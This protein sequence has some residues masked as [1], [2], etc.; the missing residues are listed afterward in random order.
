MDMMWVVQRVVSAWSLVVWCWSVLTSVLS[1][2]GRASVVRGGCGSLQGCVCVVGGWGVVVALVRCWGLPWK[3]GFTG[4]YFCLVLVVYEFVVCILRLI[5][6]WRIDMVVSAMLCRVS[7]VDFR[8]WSMC[9][10]V[11][12]VIIW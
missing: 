11:F 5:L 4:T 9:A 3:R 7:C 8:S 12:V 1:R 2:W 6:V 10:A